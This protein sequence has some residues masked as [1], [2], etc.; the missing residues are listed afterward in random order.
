VR[1]PQAPPASEFALLE[2]ISPK[3]LFFK[4]I[5]WRHT[6]ALKAALAGAEGSPLEQLLIDR[7]ALDLVTL[8]HAEYMA[9]QPTKATDPFHLDAS[10][11]ERRIEDAHRRLLRSIKVLADVRRLL[12]PAV[13]P[14]QILGRMG[15]FDH[16]NGA[17]SEG[18]TKRLKKQSH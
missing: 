3:D 6:A 17:E 4:E 12:R 1:R 7:I 16:S 13:A 15:G 5:V 11:W 18:P 9:A 8:H 10:R 2:R 14:I